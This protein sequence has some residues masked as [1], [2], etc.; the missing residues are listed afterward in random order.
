MRANEHYTCKEML[1]CLQTGGGGGK[2]NAAKLTY[3]KHSISFK[4]TELNY[5]L[6]AIT[7]IENQLARYTA[8]QNDVMSYVTT[9]L[10]AQ[11]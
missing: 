7:T 9:A 10:G 5:L 1:I 8:A 3:H 11:K 4:L 6:A 2:D